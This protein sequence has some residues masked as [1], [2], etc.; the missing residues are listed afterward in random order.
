VKFA[1]WRA[2]FAASP[3]TPFREHVDMAEADFSRL[4]LRNLRTFGHFERVENMTG[5][6][7]PDIDYCITGVEGKIESKW[8]ERWPSAST[9]VVTLEHFTAAQRLW[10]R[11]RAAAGGRTY[12]ALQVSRPVPTYFLLDGEWAAMYLGTSATREHIER[13]ALATGAAKFPT[14]MFVEALTR[15]RADARTRLPGVR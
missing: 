2:I 1:F 15:K 9:A 10:I 7:F 11:A 14:L 5:R 4:M 3:D 12:V 6:G 13:G 8:R